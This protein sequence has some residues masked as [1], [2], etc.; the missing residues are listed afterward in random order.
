MSASNKRELIIDAALALAAKVGYQNITQQAVAIAAGVAKGTVTYHFVAMIKL[1]DAVMKRAVETNDL[2][3][4]AQ[5]LTGRNWYAL[6]A[7]ESVRKNAALFL[8]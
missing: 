3:I 5:G 7:D 8:I 4:I 1:Q 6:H 2:R